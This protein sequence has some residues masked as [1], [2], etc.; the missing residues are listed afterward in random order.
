MRRNKEKMKRES[1]R[2]QVC[3]WQ[4]K[5]E[6]MK[7]GWDQENELWRRLLPSSLQGG[8]LGLPTLGHVLPAVHI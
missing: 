3:Q 2:F 7:S 1:P 6:V 5:K 4:K 8:L